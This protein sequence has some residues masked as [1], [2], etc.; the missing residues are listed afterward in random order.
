[1]TAP[2]DERRKKLLIK[3]RHILE[4]ELIALDKECRELVSAHANMSANPILTSRVTYRNSNGKLRSPTYEDVNLVN[5]NRPLYSGLG[6][7]FSYCVY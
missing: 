1:M 2:G 4:K 3:Q 5:F 7:I 6:P